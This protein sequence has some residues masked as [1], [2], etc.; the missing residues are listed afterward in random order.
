MARRS[1]GRS[2]GRSA[3]MR[4]L[5]KAARDNMTAPNLM[6]AGAVALGAAAFAYLRDEQRRTSLMDTARRWREEL[7]NRMPS[8]MRG[9]ETQ[10]AQTIPT[11][12]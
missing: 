3:S 8:M 1:D 7:P 4:R 12:P 6:A 5:K 2:N 10:T 11:L 9:H